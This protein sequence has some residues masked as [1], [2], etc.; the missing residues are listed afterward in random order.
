MVSWAA[1]LINIGMFV[2][3][4]VVAGY[5]IGQMKGVQEQQ[6]QRILRLEKRYNGERSREQSHKDR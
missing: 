1:V 3:A 6:N 5:N 4:L 2:V